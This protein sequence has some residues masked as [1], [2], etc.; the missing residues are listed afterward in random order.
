[1]KSKLIVHVDYGSKGNSGFYIERILKIRPSDVDVVAFVHSEFSPIQ[2]VEGVIKIFDRF[3]R[4]IYLNSLKNL[5]KFMELYV[6]LFFIFVFLVWKSRRNEVTVFCSVFQAFR[7]YYT[8]FASACRFASLNV[9]VHDAVELSHNYPAVVMCKR[10]DILRKADRL[11][12]HGDESMQ[13]LRY[14]DIPLVK[15][16]FPVRQRQSEMDDLDGEAVRFLFLGHIRPEKGVEILIDAWS[17]I[18]DYWRMRAELTI[19]GSDP[20]QMATRAADIENCEVLTGYVSDEEFETLI[21]RAHYVVLP[22][23]GGTNSGI[24]AEA[25]SFLRPAITSRIPCFTQTAFFLES[26]SF[27]DPQDLPELIE[28]VIA[29]HVDRYSELVSE[30]SE[31]LADYQKEF[32][33]DVVNLYKISVAL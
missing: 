17:S 23:T 15:I 2:P 25:S 27:D 5:I 26:L 12:V 18:G 32:G 21:A 3:S 16:K 19:A 7:A 33:N 6:S 31:R 30:L 28:N 20:D 13:L 10:D 1:M 11:V 24:L 14:L 9:I 29:N 22:Y 4:Y 8:F